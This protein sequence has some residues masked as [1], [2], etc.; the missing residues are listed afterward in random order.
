MIAPRGLLLGA[1]L[2]ASC[3]ALEAPGYDAGPGITCYDDTDCAPN[4]C[5]GMGTAV[6]HKSE[7]PDCS[8]ATCSGSCP[9]NG[10]KCGCAVPV[11]R[12]QRCTSAIATTPGC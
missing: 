10:I 12:I 6:V 7:A 4:G 11:C 8:A 1:L 2:L 9:L 5:C 3:G